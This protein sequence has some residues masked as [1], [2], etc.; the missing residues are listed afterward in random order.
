MARRAGEFF[1]EDLAMQIRNPSGQFAVTP[2]AVGISIHG[3]GTNV[4]NAGFA[5][6]FSGGR[7]IEW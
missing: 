7:E 6:V 5:T 1:A 4:Q 3:Y 2:S